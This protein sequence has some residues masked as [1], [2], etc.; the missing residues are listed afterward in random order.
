MSIDLVKCILKCT[1]QFQKAGKL[2]T[3]V[4]L[5]IVFSVLGE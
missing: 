2:K 4:H 3:G 1:F 5:R